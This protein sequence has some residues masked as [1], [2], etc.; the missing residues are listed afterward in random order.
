M[1]RPRK[2]TNSWFGRAVGSLYGAATVAIAVL[3]NPPHGTSQVEQALTAAAIIATGV[4]V[5][6]AVWKS[7]LTLIDGTLTVRQFGTSRSVHIADVVS[8]KPAFLPCTGLI[9]KTTQGLH[10]RTLATGSAGDER[11]V[12]RADRIC[13]ELERLGRDARVK[14]SIDQ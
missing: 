1:T 14:G 10:V 12:T 11:W 2:W 7:S 13:A 6:A 5:V 9:I 4:A 8:V 3:V